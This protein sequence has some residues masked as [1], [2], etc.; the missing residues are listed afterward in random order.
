MPKIPGIIP[1]LR[2][3]RALAKAG[4]HIAR[5]G[6]AHRHDRRQADPDYSKARPRGRAHHG[7]YCPGCRP[8]TPAIP[9]TSLKLLAVIRKR[10]FWIAAGRLLA[11]WPLRVAQACGTDRPNGC[12]SRRSST[13]G[14]QA[15]WQ[16]PT[17]W[18]IG[19]PDPLRGDDIAGADR[20]LAKAVPLFACLLASVSAVGRTPLQPPSSP[21]SRLGC[22]S[23][24]HD[25]NGLTRKRGRWIRQAA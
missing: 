12:D 7:R 22:S 11:D 4:F 1:H 18:S 8:Y 23:V 9:R 15:G 16:R 19:K 10:S 5:Q 24:D 25:R 21:L 20:P 3:V 2:A 17:P 6:K 14:R 13:W